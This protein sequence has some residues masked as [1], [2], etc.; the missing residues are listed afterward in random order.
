MTKFDQDDLYLIVDFL[1]E[2]LDNI[3]NADISYTNDYEKSLEN[4]EANETICELTI[5]VIKSLI[6]E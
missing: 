2:Q 1:E 4:L 3:R 6:K 5:E